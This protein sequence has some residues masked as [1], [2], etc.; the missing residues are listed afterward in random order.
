MVA[1]VTA[2]TGSPPTGTPRG[3]RRS[4]LGDI[5]F[6]GVSVLMAVGLIA[7]LCLLLYELGSGGARAFGRFGLRFITGKSWNPVFGR[8]EFGA[9]PFIFGTLVTSAIAIVLA[10]PVAVGLALLLNEVKTGWIRDPLAVFVDLLAAIPSVVYGL[11]A[12]FIMK[13]VF[14]HRVEPFLTATIGKVP[15]IGVLFRGARFCVQTDPTTGACQRFGFNSNG[16]DLFTAGVILA[17]MILP[18]VTAVTREVV[19]VVPRELREG[20]LALGATRYETMRMA[21]LP[22]ARSGIV[23]ATMLGLGRALGETIAVSMVVGNG[24]GIGASLFKAGYTI[25][26]VIASEFREA[27]S[28]GVHRSALLALA[29][30]LV[31]IALILA[32]LS[33]LLVGRTAKLVGGSAVPAAEAPVVQVTG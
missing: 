10:V 26:A 23:G 1:R 12:L 5:V 33:R 30:L 14:D 13:P 20:A 17:I 32:A 8:E 29:L 2:D 9:L 3:W 31:V 4:R 7:L 27:T 18:I 15:L 24:L 28:V 6:K 25:P 16:G 22:Y 19:A 11:W 21:V